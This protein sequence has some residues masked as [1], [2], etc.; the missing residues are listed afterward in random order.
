MIPISI[1]IFCY[2]R[3]FHTVRRQRKVVDGHES[4]GEDTGITTTSHNENA[5]QV[6]QQATEA[7]TGNTLSRIELNMVKTM[8]TIII[9][10][11]VLW[12]VPTV[13]SV[14]HILG[15]SMTLCAIVL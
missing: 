1:F 2:G 4:S 10:F 8:I 9:C 15:V 7:T 13:V 12:A 6:Q 5:G 11:M 14:L 3:I